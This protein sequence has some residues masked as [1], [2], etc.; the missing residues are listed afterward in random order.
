MMSCTML[1]GALFYVVFYYHKGAER[2]ARVNWGRFV[3]KISDI[4]NGFESKWYN[5]LLFQAKGDEVGVM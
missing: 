5:W 1:F 2:Q 4:W 3:T